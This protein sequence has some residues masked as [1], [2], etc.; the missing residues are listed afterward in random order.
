MRDAEPPPS[1]PPYER[2][3]R[4]RRR[5][6][7]AGSDA[8]L[9]VETYRVTRPDLDRRRYLTV[10]RKRLFWT[11]ATF[12]FLFGAVAVKATIATVIN[13][14]PPSKPAP[15]LASIVE[16]AVPRESPDVV[17]GGRRATI[18]DRN[19]KVLAVSLPTVSLFAD[20]RH[21]IDPLDATRKL[22][23]VLPRLDEER[24][25]TRLS[26]ERKFVYLERQIT[27]QEQVEINNLGLPGIEFKPIGQRQYPLGRTAAHV[28]GGVNVDEIGVAGV[29]KAFDQRLTENTA[30]LR[31]SIDVAV[32]TAV[33]EEL[34]T[35]IT[36]YEAIGGAGIV[37]DVHTG[38]IIALVSMP[39]YDA[40]QFRQTGGVERFNRTITGRYEPG[41]TFKLQTAAMA[42]DYG[43]ARTWDSFDATNPIT[44][45]RFTISDFEGK[46]RVLAFPEVLA[47]SSNIAA[48]KMAQQVGA[49]RQ[50][51][52]L[53][54]MGMFDRVGIELPE[55]DRPMFQSAAQWKEIATLT[56]GFGHGISVTPMHIVKGL[57]AI[58]NGGIVRPPTILA[59]DP[60]QQPAGVRVMKP[61]TSDTMR[62]M[63]RLI[64]T[65]GFGKTAEAPGF[66]PGGK[67]GTAEKSGK[68]GY[69]KKANVTAF[70]GVFPMHAPRY[71]VYMMLD[72]GKGNKSTYGYSTAGWL[73]A[74]AAG[75]VIKRVGPILGVMP[76]TANAATIT[77]QLAFPLQPTRPANPPRGPMVASDRPAPTTPK[78]TLTVPPTQLPPASVPTNPPPRRHQASP[79]LPNTQPVPP[80]RGAEP[81]A[82]S[83]S[84]AQAPRAPAATPLA[85]AVPAHAGR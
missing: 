78:P 67:T 45:G 31:L 3:R 40:N 58:A 41:S 8:R 2:L 62:K 17:V 60:A 20:P 73:V 9:G 30:P 26:S 63:M 39:D 57:A 68:G 32:Q 25:I 14:R 84:L 59:V 38:E 85:L 23:S 5:V 76:D 36:K 27:R 66:Y 61:E 48:A 4:L 56:V 75:E 7:A 16:R 71:A 12:T 64:V 21:I 55:S 29:E 10:A 28:L 46:K 47:Y 43:T 53:K 54:D 65:D 80:A 35:A 83:G 42:L 33:R 81:P 52:W 34:L 11:V 44:I 69:K 37:M 49:E 1:S 77:Q 22:K 50:R 79:D 6:G 51:K 18:T 13:P 74:P 70:A 82:P 24:A 72:E 15:Q 19:G